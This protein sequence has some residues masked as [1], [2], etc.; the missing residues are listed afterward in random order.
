MKIGKNIYRLITFAPVPMGD[1]AVRGP[2]ELEAHPADH[3]L[4]GR[5]PHLRR[6]QHQ[7]PI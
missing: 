3:R 2:G 5:R 4:Q 1:E 7:A 6:P